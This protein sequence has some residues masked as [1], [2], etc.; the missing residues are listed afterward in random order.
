V[1]P[2]VWPVFATY[3][4]VLVWLLLANLAVVAASLAV[5]GG[6]RVTPGILV[7][8]LTL[9][10]AS[11]A[12]ASL[13][14]SQLSG[15]PPSVRL[16]TGPGRLSWPAVGLGVAGLLALSQAA[17]VVLILLGLRTRGALGFLQELIARIS[18]PMLILTLLVAGVLAAAAEEL[19]FR[20]FVET[21]LAARW[22]RWRAIGITAAGFAV[23]H[24]DPVHAAFALAVGLF[25]G[26]TTELAASIRP[27]VAAHVANNCVSLL[28]TWWPSGSASDGQR[29]GLLALSLAVSAG[30][31][32]LLRR[33]DPD[34]SAV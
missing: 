26:W 4:A 22:G 20:G 10:A 17:D 2:R 32:V 24:L 1:R 12:V 8:T 13:V 23:F 19:F 7:G 3:G 25:L 6:M 27:A 33:S 34:R 30:A 29:A 9:N 31:I 11:L 16:R 5:T 14:G 21:R 18:G 28:Q 15:E